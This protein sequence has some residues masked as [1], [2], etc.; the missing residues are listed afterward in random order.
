MEKD[1]GATA[2][3]ETVEQSAEAEAGLLEFMNGAIDRLEPKGPEA[4][5]PEETP[6]EEGTT[7]L[8]QPTDPPPA[9]E[10]QADDEAEDEPAPT[11]PPEAQERI[12]KRIGKE[13]AKTKAEREA[14]Q[15][16]EARLAELEAKLKEK[17]AVQPAIQEPPPNGD[18][19]L[20][21]PEIKKIWDQEQK[22]ETANK[23][24][25]QLLR[26]LEDD[27]EGVVESL[28]SDLKIKVKDARHAKEVLET[29]RDNSFR[30]QLSL[31]SDRKVAAFQHQQKMVTQH[32]I[33]VEETAKDFP[34]LKDPA[35]K[36]YKEGEAIL[37]NHPNLWFIP[38][39]PGMLAEMVTGRL[40]RKAKTVTA[41]NAPPSKVPKLPPSP[42]ATPQPEN[43]KAAQASAVRGRAVESG[44][45]EDAARYIAE[46]LG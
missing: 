1:T 36:E 42:K 40:A 10:A 9:S 38:G 12:N 18:P 6:T 7:D 4:S 17:E 45:L 31:E 27:P 11:V 28:K 14:R 24:A 44:K 39:G 23:Q 13:V 21:V 19:L 3:A 30:K 15:K 41:T 37:K 5:Q 26:N 8:S 25:T 32:A 33:E 46:V 34:W 2:P 43:S 20:A 22:A 29:I 35:S 16:A